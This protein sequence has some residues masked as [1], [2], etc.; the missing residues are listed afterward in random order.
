[1]ST[2]VALPGAT[3]ESSAESTPLR[4]S[5]DEW[6]AW[7]HEG[8]LTEWVN[9][10]VIVMPSPSEIHQRVAGFLYG[11]MRN[12]VEL[13]R[14]GVVY[15]AP[16]DM[17]IHSDGPVRE[18]DVLFLASAHRD[19]LTTRG[20]S[21]PADIVIEVISDESA[22]RDR[23][24]KFYEY[25]EGGVREYWIVDP[26]EGKQR[27]D[28][29]VIDERGRYQPVLPVDGAYHSTVLPNFRVKEEW[30]WAEEP[31][32]LAALSSI[33]GPEQFVAAMQQSK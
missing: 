9:G 21:G 6:L 31:N 18:P 32:A 14:L 33:V 30:L 20:L 8:G 12:F 25:Q 3:T 2:D 10:D 16:F 26:R 22:A 7:D 4:M 19:R 27:V 15:S 29:Y 11:F 23:A 28:L 13:F 1:M 24:D 17:R 5:Y